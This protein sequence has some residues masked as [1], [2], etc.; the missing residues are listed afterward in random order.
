MLYRV[1]KFLFGCQ[2]YVIKVIDYL[3]LGHFSFRGCSFQRLYTN[4]NYNNVDVHYSVLNLLNECI[5][6]R[7][8]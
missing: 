3:N 7:D 4:M 6:L 2:R 8:N 1:G 5:L